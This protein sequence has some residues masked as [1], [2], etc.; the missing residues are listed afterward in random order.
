MG[1]A[2]DSYEETA[3][4]WNENG[5]LEPVQPDPYCVMKLSCWIHSVGAAQ[6]GV[7]QCLRDY[8][9][10][11]SKVLER[12][13]RYWMDEL[14]DGKE[15]CTFCGQSWRAENCSLCTVCSTA[16]PPCC[17]EKRQLKVLSNGNRECSVCH[18]GEIVG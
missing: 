8:F 11:L 15:F 1:Y 17:S 13:D 6:D 12:K 16:Y 10:A 3:R 14:L 4:Q 2:S 9:Q 7:S 18:K 5:R